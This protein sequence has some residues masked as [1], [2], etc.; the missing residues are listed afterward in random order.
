MPHPCLCVRRAVRQHVTEGG[1][2]EEVRE[3]LQEQ[4]LVTRRQPQQHS[5]MSHVGLASKRLAMG[6][7]SGVYT[8]L[9][10]AHSW[11]CQHMAS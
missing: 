6:G 10:F 9:W 7:G 1:V 2:C 5:A 4:L 11:H 8:R 3:R